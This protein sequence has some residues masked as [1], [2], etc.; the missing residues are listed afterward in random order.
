MHN[1]RYMRTPEAKERLSRIHSQAKVHAQHIRRVERR[2]E[3]A[4]QSRG[5]EVDD[6]L[7]QDLS[8][9]VTEHSS[10]VKEHFP[11][12]SFSRIFWEQQEKAIKMTNAKSMR[13]EPAMIRWVLSVSVI[14]I[15]TYV[16]QMVYILAT[17]VKFCIWVAV[18]IRC[19]KT[20]IT[21]DLTWLHVLHAVVQWL[22]GICRSADN[23]HGKHQ[24][25]LRKRQVCH[26]HYGW[27]AHP[28]RYCL[29]QAIRCVLLG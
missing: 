11:P 24:F 2:L 17:L 16:T 5:V 25:L 9:T 4:I 20:S 12:G 7:H 15:C 6:S 1:Y 19:T 13:C 3:M 28:T 29:W 10:S 18:H 21:E 27:N 23:G 26:H 8:N 14:V 22:F